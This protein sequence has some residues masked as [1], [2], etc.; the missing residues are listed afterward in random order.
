MSSNFDLTAAIEA[1]RNE[2]AAQ[3]Q[4]TPDDRRE[5]ERHLADSI[6]DFRGRGFADEEAFWLARRRIGQPRQLAEEYEKADS[7]KVWRQRMFWI[8]LAVLV[9]RLFFDLVRSVGLVVVVAV[10]HHGFVRWA[11]VI[12]MLIPFLVP[13]LFFV[14]MASGKLVPR[15][16][17]LT[18]LVRD[19]QRLAMAI[20]IVFI[21]V[22]STR[23]AAYWTLSA[24]G[25]V[26]KMP[27]GMLV[28]YVIDVSNDLL[29]GLVAIW[30]M[31]AERKTLRTA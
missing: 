18:G 6:A 20:F 26:G 23:V 31:P 2:L 5:L 21:L 12:Q 29:L 11:N 8:A 1:W 16:Q 3:P 22:I 30:L 10:P 4:L 27:F 25:M 19:R 13:L 17:K 15:L 24:A 28:W 7:L 14:L 9:W